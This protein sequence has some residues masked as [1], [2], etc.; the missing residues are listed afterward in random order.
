MRKVKIAAVT[1]LMLGLMPSANADVY[2]KVDAN[3]NAVG[4]AIMCDAG[5]CADGS[6]YSKATL[7]PGERY[8]LQNQGHAGIGN[9]NP[10]VDVKVDLT[11]NQWTATTTTVK[12]V[13]PVQIAPEVKVTKVEVVT[14]TTWNPTKPNPAPQPAPIQVVSS[15]PT[16]VTSDTGTVTS[17]VAAPAPIVQ[18]KPVEQVGATMTTT[19]IVKPWFELEAFDWELFWQEFSVWLAAWDWNWND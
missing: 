17:N 5:T 4:Q 18:P 11:T 16:V 8:V 13:A 10:G 2:V 3:G 14:Q 9:N 19:Q 7:A 6:A 12:E 15:P 1:L